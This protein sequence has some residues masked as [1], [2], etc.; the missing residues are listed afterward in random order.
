MCNARQSYHF[1][2]HTTES[3][4]NS[5]Y[6]STPKLTSQRERERERFMRKRNKDLRTVRFPNFGEELLWHT[7]ESERKARED[8]QLGCPD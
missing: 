4:R 6:T 5:N 1:S 8:I 3:R 2:Y 7:C